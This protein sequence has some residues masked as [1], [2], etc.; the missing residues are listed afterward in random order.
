[1]ADMAPI[2]PI[3]MNESVS[4]S[5]LSRSPLSLSLARSLARSL[6]LSLSLALSLSRL[7][8]FY[9][10]LTYAIP[11]TSNVVK[12]RWEASSPPLPDSKP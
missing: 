7:H 1:M 6:Y 4:V 9:I 3:G 2:R 12:E 5:S 8:A 11:L 10:M